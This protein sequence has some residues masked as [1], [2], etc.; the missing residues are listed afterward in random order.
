M[1]KQIDTVQEGY[2]PVTG[3]LIW[4]KVVNP[5][6]SIPLLTLHGGPGSS[7]NYLEPLEQLA[8]ERPIIFYDQLAVCRRETGTPRL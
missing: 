7:H 6:N 2:I 4:Y 5:G 8:S 3:G 1:L